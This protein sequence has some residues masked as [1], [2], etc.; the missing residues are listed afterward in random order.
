MLF[1]TA[2]R[3]RVVPEWLGIGHHR[4]DVLGDERDAVGLGLGKDASRIERLGLVGRHDS[5]DRLADLVPARLCSK[6]GFGLVYGFRQ[7]GDYRVAD[8]R[9]AV[10][11]CWARGWRTRHGLSISEIR[12][13]FNYGLPSTA[14][15]AGHSLGANP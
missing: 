12:V 13:L 6:E 15:P 14:W 4:L 1:E 3:H 10:R 7:P 2:V 9:R 11:D 5:V 8:S